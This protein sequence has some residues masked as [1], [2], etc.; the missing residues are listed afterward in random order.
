MRRILGD[1]TPDLFLRR[2]GYQ[3]F[4][5]SPAAGSIHI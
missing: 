2:R 4:V 1:L 5:T 3:Q